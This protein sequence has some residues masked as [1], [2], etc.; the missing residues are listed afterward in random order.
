MARSSRIIHPV[1]PAQAGIQSLPLQRQG[2]SDVRGPWVP[3]FAGT[4]RSGVI[5]LIGICFRAARSLRGA[6]QGAPELVEGGNL[7]QARA[8]CPMEIASSRFADNPL[9]RFVAEPFGSAREASGRVVR[10][11]SPVWR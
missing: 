1:I 9:G 3:A 6:R 7:P 10:N 8:R 2:A 11:D 5:Y 4:A